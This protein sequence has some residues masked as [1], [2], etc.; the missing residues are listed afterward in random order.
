MRYSA[1]SK[2]VSYLKANAAEAL[3]KLTEGREALVITQ[4]GEAKAVTPG[5][6]PTWRLT[7]KEAEISAEPSPPRR[8]PS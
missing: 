2:P 4:N 6:S 5:A 3:A 8:A 1:Q 7:R